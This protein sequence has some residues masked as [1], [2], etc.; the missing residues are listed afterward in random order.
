M[1]G[2]RL[3]QPTNAEISGREYAERFRREVRFECDEVSAGYPKLFKS[4]AVMIDQPQREKPAAVRSFNLDSYLEDKSEHDETLNRLVHDRFTQVVK[5][6][7][8]EFDQFTR[9]TPET[10]NGATFSERIRKQY[11]DASA[12]SIVN[13]IIKK[14]YTAIAEETM[15]EA[16]RRRYPNSASPEDALEEELSGMLRRDTAL[17]RFVGLPSEDELAFRHSSRKADRKHVRHYLEKAQQEWIQAVTANID[18]YVR[19]QYVPGNERQILMRAFGWHTRL[20]RTGTPL[21]YQRI[22]E[23]ILIDALLEIA[24]NV[25]ALRE[26]EYYKEAKRRA[27]S[28]DRSKRAQYHLPKL[29]ADDDP[30]AL[31]FTIVGRTFQNLRF[32]AA[33]RGWND[34]AFSNPITIEKLLGATIQRTVSVVPNDT[35]TNDEFDDNAP[36]EQDDSPQGED[37]AVRAPSWAAVTQAWYEEHHYDT[38][39]KV[40]EDEDGKP[41][42]GKN[43]KPVKVTR[44]YIPGAYGDPYVPKSAIS[45]ND[46]HS[47]E[48]ALEQSLDQIARNKYEYASVFTVRQEIIRTT[49]YPIFSWLNAQLNGG[50]NDHGTK[51]TTSN[52]WS[53]PD[54]NV[55]ALQAAYAA[56]SSYG[57]SSKKKTAFID[58]LVKA[59]IDPNTGAPDGVNFDTGKKSR[60]VIAKYYD[61]GTVFVRKLLY[62]LGGLG[63]YP[64]FGDQYALQEE[65]DRLSKK[66]YKTALRVVSKSAPATEWVLLYHGYHLAARVIPTDWLNLMTGSQDAARDIQS[67]V[68]NADKVID[69]SKAGGGTKKRPDPIVAQA[70]HLTTRYTGCEVLHAAEHVIIDASDSTAA[71]CVDTYGGRKCQQ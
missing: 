52:V 28:V 24:W 29:T 14:W 45:L 21:T 6:W 67:A 13:A 11:G 10:E 51:N 36:D 35:D 59:Y 71:L 5:Q 12:V 15:T 39:E 16:I 37:L 25:E 63:R 1:S 70:Q 22:V 38:Y 48:S 58:A 2:E 60:D 57:A 26:G 27:I 65:M 18:Q 61:R 46:E 30:D 31:M 47:G 44:R 3:V 50:Q 56:V 17:A 33:N 9:S 66:E 7:E 43:G 4:A 53:I 32:T 8:G 34:E 42:L 49:L 41:V 68:A 20:G 69:G 62:V 55:Y 40:K 54:S 64:L 19:Y 23:W